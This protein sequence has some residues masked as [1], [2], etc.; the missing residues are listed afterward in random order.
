MSLLSESGEDGTGGR[1]RLVAWAGFF[2][3]LSLLV[4]LV[5]WQ[6]A[7]AVVDAFDRAGWQLL[8]LP[9]LFVAGPLPLSALSWGALF[10]RDRRPA[11]WTTVHGSWVG[12]AVNSLLPVAM[13]GGEVVRVR[14]L[15]KRGGDAATGSA[16]VVADKTLM[17]AAQALTSLVGLAFL[18][19]RRPDPALVLG[20]LAGGVLLGV[21]TILFVRAQHRGLFQALAGGIARMGLDSDAL[22]GG[23]RDADRLLEEIYR[24]RR[25]VAEAFA[26]RLLARVFLVGEIWLALRFLGIP[27][28][29]VDALILDFLGQTVRAAAFL[30][31]AGLGVQEGGFALLAAA[32]GIPP[33]TGLTVSLMRRVREVALGGPALLAWQVEEGGRIFGSGSGEDS[34]AGGGRV[35]RGREGGAPE[36]PDPGTSEP[37]LRVKPAGDENPSRA[38]TGPSGS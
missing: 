21:L 28:T 3:G 8:W 15:G 33:A 14:L 11:F 24:D 27:V 25:R 10:P 31:P 7:G 12:S 37:D 18:A 2:L 4:A 36:G 5:W 26:W 1:R 6:G 17:A 29:V 30:V 16:T 22:G 35:S 34:A 23:A 13:V 20:A 38:R 19:V 32:L 9:V